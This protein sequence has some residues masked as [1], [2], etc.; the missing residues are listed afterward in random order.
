MVKLGRW[1]RQRTVLKGA[2]AVKTGHPGGIRPV[3]FT[4]PTPET[5]DIEV[6]SLERM[7]VRSGREEFLDTQRL[8]FDML[9][10]VDRGEAVHTVDFTT[11]PLAPGDVLWVRAGQVQQWG[12][13]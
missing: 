6:L 10:R 9:L 1:A 8:D 11:H 2:D 12:R 13:I 7:R 5:G 4:P 3:R